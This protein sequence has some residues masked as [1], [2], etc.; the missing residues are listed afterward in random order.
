VAPG[1]VG[2]PDISHVF[3]GEL[4]DLIEVVGVDDRDHPATTASEVDRLVLRL[5]VRFRSTHLA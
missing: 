2:G 4:E 5:T 1:C 3:L